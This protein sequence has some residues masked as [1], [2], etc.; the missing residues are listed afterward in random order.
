LAQGRKG[1]TKKERSAAKCETRKK[2][3]E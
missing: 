1:N 2:P 3:W